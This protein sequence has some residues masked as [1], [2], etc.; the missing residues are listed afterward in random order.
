[1]SGSAAAPRCRDR[2]ST[3]RHRLTSTVFITSVIR[4]CDRSR[5]PGARNFVDPQPHRILDGSV[6][7]VGHADRETRHVVHEEVGEVFCGDHD[8]RPQHHSPA[9]S[10]RIRDRT[11]RRTHLE[12]R[13]IGL[14]GPTGDSRRVTA[15]TCVDQ[16]VIVCAPHVR[17]RSAPTTKPA[18]PSLAPHFRR[19]SASTTKPAPPSLAPHFRRRPCRSLQLSN[20][21]PRLR[22]RNVA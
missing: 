21:V 14:I 12:Q 11:T 10:S 2:T 7:E 3:P 6:V 16:C 18:P 22:A 8:H 1:M 19:R 13:W 9:M 20:R 15:H 17:R 5:L 4:R